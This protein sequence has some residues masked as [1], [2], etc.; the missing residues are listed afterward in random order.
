[1]SSNSL[2][3][4]VQMHDNY[5]Y[6]MSC[7][8]IY[9]SK[10]SVES[11]E[12]GYERVVQSN[13]QT[14]TNGPCP[15]PRIHASKIKFDNVDKDPRGSTNGSKQ[16]GYYSDWV[17]YAKTTTGSK[18]VFTFFNSTW[19]VP[20]TPSSRGPL[21]LSS[22]Y[23]FNGLEDGAGHAGNAS[24][25]LQQCNMESQD[26]FFLLQTEAMESCELP[27]VGFWPGALWGNVSRSMMAMTSLGL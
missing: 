5:Y 13:G 24:L 3:G 9:D 18:N 23:L 12:G 14:L 10:F 22:I 16:L 21:G 25:I 4:Y 1:M 26:V 8:H 19:K 15:Y 6:H 7:V 27:G 2:V 20:P 11:L 17:A